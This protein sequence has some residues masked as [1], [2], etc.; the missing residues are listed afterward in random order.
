VGSGCQDMRPVKREEDCTRCR[1]RMA[2]REG[3]RAVGGWEEGARREG[4]GMGM[5]SSQ[6]KVV[7]CHRARHRTT[8]LLV[9]IRQMVPSQ[10]PIATTR[11][12]F[13]GF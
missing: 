8:R 13:G 10:C 3:A 7:L 2:I 12:P 5:A 1:G 9:S 11:G 6:A 4:M